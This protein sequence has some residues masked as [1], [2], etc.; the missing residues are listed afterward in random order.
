[1][2]SRIA[3]SACIHLPLIQTSPVASAAQ[4]TTQ[5]REVTAMYQQQSDELSALRKEHAALKTAYDTAQSQLAAGGGGGGSDSS[6]ILAQKDSDLAAARAKSSELI[7]KL[8]RLEGEQVF[9]RKKAEQAAAVVEREKEEEIAA[10]K[11]MFTEVSEKR[12]EQFLALKDRLK[13]TVDLVTKGN[14]RAAADAS[15]I[16]DLQAKLAAADRALKDKTTEVQEYDARVRALESEKG[17]DVA[18]LSEDLQQSR[19]EARDYQGQLEG[20]Q[21]SVHEIGSRCG[22]TVASC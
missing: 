2:G 21:R 11:V 8:D 5:L 14:E 1:M 18:R 9:L 17:L 15:V 4:L 3:R 16:A 10:L 13:Q 6:A 19:N 22:S 12:K 7:A 20:I